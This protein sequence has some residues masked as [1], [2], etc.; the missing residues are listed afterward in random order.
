M[1]LISRWTP[2][3]L[4]PYRGGHRQLADASVRSPIVGGIR[5]RIARG[6]SGTSA[7]EK[8]AAGGVH[9]RVRGTVPL[10]PK[11]FFSCSGMA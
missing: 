10:T 11:S 6:G 7:Q 5:H 1:T 3:G 4:S 8:V 9:R 2:V